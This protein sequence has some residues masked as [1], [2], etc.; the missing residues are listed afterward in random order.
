MT[1]KQRHFNKVYENASL[2]KC[3]CGCG[4]LI[5][6]KDEYARPKRFANGHNRRKYKDLTQYKREWNK[7]NKVTR[8]I[9]HNKYCALKKVELIKLKGGRCLKCGIK[10]NGKNAAMFQ[11]HHR[12]PKLKEFAIGLN[13]VWKS[14]KKLIKELEK[15]DLM[16]ANC[17]SLK[18]SKEY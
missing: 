9:Y 10:Y 17:H 5:K 12:N 4:N 8:K 15:C 18:H 3:S 16:C 11:F 14:R 1:P 2:V 13:S 7:R 6:N